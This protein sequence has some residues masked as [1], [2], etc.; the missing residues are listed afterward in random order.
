MGACSLIVLQLQPATPRT[1]KVKAEHPQAQILSPSKPQPQLPLNQNQTTTQSICVAAETASSASSAANSAAL[2]LFKSLSASPTPAPS[3]IHRAVS[4]PVPSIILLHAARP[5][6]SHQ[7]TRRLSPT[8]RLDHQQRRVNWQSW[9]RWREGMS[10][11]R[12]HFGL[13]FPSRRTR[14]TDQAMVGTSGGLEV[15]ANIA[16]AHSSL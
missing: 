11:R 8:L 4:R 15:W 2:P 9:R 16:Q 12:T 5:R 1:I 6:A 10:R 7:H 13:A 3:A 14:A